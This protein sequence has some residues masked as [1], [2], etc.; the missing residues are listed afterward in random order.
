[1]M[2]KVMQMLMMII[3]VVIIFMKASDDKIFL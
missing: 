3:S 1:M 2:V